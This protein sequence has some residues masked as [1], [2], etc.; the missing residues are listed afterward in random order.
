MTYQYLGCKNCK[1]YEE[2]HQYPN[3]NAYARHFCKK[4][5]EEIRYV[6]A[7]YYSDFYVVWLPKLC[8]FNDYF[9]ESEQAR[10]ERERREKC[11]IEMYQQV[12]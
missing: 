8:Y 6:K 4:C 5:N 7:G 12:E 9:E 3:P 1:Y 2:F 11:I 10:K